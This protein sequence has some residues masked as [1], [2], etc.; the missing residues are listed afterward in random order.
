ME[1][2]ERMRSLV[3]AFHQSGMTQ[4]DFAAS[5]DIGFHKSNYWVR[6]LRNETLHKNGFV[7]VKPS[8][9]Y[10]GSATIRVKSAISLED[11]QTS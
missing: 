11:I 8:V 4:K 9:S 7:K 6:K 3:E 5:H 2:A 10:R 1:L